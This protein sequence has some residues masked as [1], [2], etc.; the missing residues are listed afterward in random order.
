MKSCFAALAALIAAL[1]LASSASAA[2]PQT[3]SNLIVPGKSVA[4]V[5]LGMLMTAAAN[6]WRMEEGQSCFR[7]RPSFPYRCL[8][9]PA[10][11]GANYNLGVLVYEGRKKVEQIS[12]R[13]PTDRERPDFSSAMNR[14]KTAGGIGIGTRLGK[15]KST[16][17]KAL[18]LTTPGAERIF[19]VT[20]PGKAKTEFTVFGVQVSSISLSQP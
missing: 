15:L 16:F 8:F 13:A 3:K 20:G 17:G 7:E 11:S 14:Y 12:I 1:V 19:T 9:E 4:G 6:V 5:K 2:L 10:S 18:K